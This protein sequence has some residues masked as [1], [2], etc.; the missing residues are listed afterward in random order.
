VFGSEEVSNNTFDSTAGWYP[1]RLASNITAVSN[2]LRTTSTSGST[3]GA[4]VA[5]T[6]LVIGKAYLFAGSA[7][8]NNSGITIRF[9]VHETEDLTSSIISV[10]GIGSVTF[11]TIFT[12]SATTMHVGVIATGAS[13]GDYVNI[14]AGVSVKSVTNYISYENIAVEDRSTNTII[15]GAYVGSEKVINGDFANGTDN[16]TAGSGSTITASGGVLTVLSPSPD[17][18][19]NASQPFATVLGVRYEVNISLGAEVGSTNIPMGI[20]SNPTSVRDILELDTAVGNETSTGYFVGDGN[21]VYIIVGV[22][23]SGATVEVN[24]ASIKT[25]TIIAAQN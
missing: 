14:E 22:Q 2:K 8:S 21:T 24:Y 9:R 17:D 18:F 5:L 12:A 13:I 20:S 10:Q 1:P 19:G 7:I 3:F 25:S 4:A 15:N 11:D 6:G 16:W 23:G